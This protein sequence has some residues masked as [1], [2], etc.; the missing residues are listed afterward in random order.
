[1]EKRYGHNLAKYGRNHDSKQTSQ[2]A[3]VYLVVDQRHKDRERHHRRPR[4]AHGDPGNGVN[5]SA[6]ARVP[7]VSN[8]GQPGA[9]P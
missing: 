2:I 4:A 5:D 8:N 1:M 7:G 6:S 3:A 9:G